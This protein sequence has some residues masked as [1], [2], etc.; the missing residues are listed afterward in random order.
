L[1]ILKKYEVIDKIP[2]I[3]LH[4]LKQGSDGKIPDTPLEEDK[5]FRKVTN[6]VI[7]NNRLALDKAKEKAESLGFRTLI[8]TSMLEGEAKEIAKVVASIIKE[9]QLTRTPLDRPACLL[10]GGEPTV[11]IE[12]SGKGGRNQELALAVALSDIREQYVF[13]S[14]GSDGTDGPTDAAGAIVDNTTLN[15]AE[16]AGLNAREYLKNNDAYNFF[17]PLGDLIITGPTGTNVMDVVF[18]LIP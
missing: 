17:S 7:G 13:V 9:I 16:R 15:R 12:G 10:M 11:K 1:T 18:A 4:H 3:I 5:V 8:L 14:F 6:I 2:S